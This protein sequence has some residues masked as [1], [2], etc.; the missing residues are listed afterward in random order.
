M[1]KTA[2]GA[3]SPPVAG[4]T[5]AVAGASA[6]RVHGKEGLRLP[7]CV[8]LPGFVW[9]WLPT[10][11]HVW[12]GLKPSIYFSQA[13]LWF[14]RGPA[15]DICACFLAWWCGLLP[16]LHPAPSCFNVWKCAQHLCC[17]HPSESLR[18]GCNRA[19]G[20]SSSHCPR[21]V[22]RNMV[23]LHLW[24]YGLASAHSALPAQT[25]A[26]CSVLVFPKLPTGSWSDPMSPSNWL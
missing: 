6:P 4:L 7:G 25:K 5:L 21:L 18:V 23:S 19:A 8:Y 12:Q 1:E 15:G 26:F 16:H 3:C 14:C 10:I 9:R 11:L 2:H 22:H 13:F 24:G 17:W 20:C